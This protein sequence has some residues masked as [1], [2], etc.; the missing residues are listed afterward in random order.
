MLYN[1]LFSNI[2]ILKNNQ[3][4]FHSDD[5]LNTCI[6]FEKNSINR[7]ILY[8]SWEINVNLVNLLKFYD[9]Y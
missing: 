5:F 2:Y 9:L 3:D 8:L 7:L 1:I 4:Y 6:I